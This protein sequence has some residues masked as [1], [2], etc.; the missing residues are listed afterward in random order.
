MREEEKHGWREREKEMEERREGNGGK[1]FFILRRAF[2]GKKIRLDNA[3]LSG[4]L[5][6]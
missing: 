3:K 2:R 4:K 1:I 6:K 5:M